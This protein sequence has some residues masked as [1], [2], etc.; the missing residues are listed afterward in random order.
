M[1]L[2]IEADLDYWIDGAADVLLQVE[3]A[4]MAD[5]KLL[6]Q[7]LRVW[8]ARTADGGAGRG[9]YWPACLGAGRGRVSCR[10]RL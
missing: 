5:Q 2:R 6:H 8:C 10:I 1:R 4:A 3:V 7:D 9:L